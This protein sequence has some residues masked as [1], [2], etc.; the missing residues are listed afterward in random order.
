MKNYF[1]RKTKFHVA[2]ALLLLTVAFSCRKENAT[3]IENFNPFSKKSLKTSVFLTNSVDF[4]PRLAKIKKQFY[5][6][7]MDLKFI[8]KD[9][10]GV[11]WKPEW[12]KPIVQVVNDSVSYVFYRL[13]GS[14]I[15]GG[16]LVQAQ[17]IGSAT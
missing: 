7:K 6:R 17:D 5:L 9:D 13:R 12:A 10:K 14:L 2:F 11:I 3:V 15:R 16:K 1:K 4:A 8:P